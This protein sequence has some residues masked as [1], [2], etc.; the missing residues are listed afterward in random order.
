MN[1]AESKRSKFFKEWWEEY[2]SQLVLS[3]ESFRNI[4]EAGYNAALNAQPPHP[5]FDRDEFYGICGEDLLRIQNV[6]QELYNER[7]LNADDMRDLAHKLYYSLGEVCSLDEVKVSA[8]DPLTPEEQEELLD[9]VEEVGRTVHVTLGAGNAYFLKEEAV[10]RMT[11]LHNKIRPPYH[12]RG[13][14]KVR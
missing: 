1:P 5:K 11:A 9:L 6:M 13:G 2:A 7:T 4:A 10:A 3:G 12:L 8:F 14:K